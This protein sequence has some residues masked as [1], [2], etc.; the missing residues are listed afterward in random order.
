MSDTQDTIVF[1]GTAWCPSS[2]WARRLLAKNDI[3]YRW[4]NIDKDPEGCAYVEE[5]NNGFRSVPTILFPDGS[6][7][8]EPTISELSRK[9]GLED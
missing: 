3:E 8:V 5:V 1:Y 4:V 6:L 7:L 2:L 9:L